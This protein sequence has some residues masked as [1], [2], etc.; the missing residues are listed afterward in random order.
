[1]NLPAKKIKILSFGETYHTKSFVDQ[2]EKY[3]EGNCDVKYCDK[4]K[5]EI[6][7]EEFDIIHLISSPLP[8][9]R[10]LTR[11]NIPLIYHWI[12]TD[13]YRIINDSVFKRWLKKRILKSTK[14]TNVVVS[15]A[16]QM[17]L[18]QIG[19]DSIVLPLVKLNFIDDCPAL[20]QKFSILAYIPQDRW[21]YYHGDL[22]LQLA[23]K[24]PEVDFHILAGG[25]K[26]VNLSNVFIYD[27]IDDINSYYLN[28]SI[29]LRF[30]IHDGLPKMVIEAL[31]YGRHV[32]WNNPFPNCH[33]VQSIKDCIDVINRLKANP[34]V[35]KKGKEYVESTFRPEK[36]VDDYLNICNK[37]IEIK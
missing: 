13:V 12:G 2:L 27:F 5:E 21:D 6:N 36:I 32:L 26:F 22:V 17:E 11:Y 34:S 31:A 14:T 25:N 37:V 15:P 16:L 20:P 4:L 23:A 24:L 33:Y 35:N 3:G 30:T 1:V 19:I 9:L 8:I 10:Q 28:N 7:Y 18:K 29:L